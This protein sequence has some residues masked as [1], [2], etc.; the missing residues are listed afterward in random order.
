[1]GLG[2]LSS[3]VG[4]AKIENSLVDLEYPRSYRVPPA[5]AC[6]QSQA[7]CLGG[8]NVLLADPSCGPCGNVTHAWG[9]DALSAD[10]ATE[11]ADATMFSKFSTFYQLENPETD[12][13]LLDNELIHKMAEL[14]RI[15]KI[16]AVDADGIRD[17]AG[18]EWQ[19]G[20][21]DF[22][23]L[24][25]DLPQKLRSQSELRIAIWMLVA[26]RQQTKVL[27][28]WHQKQ[29]DEM[30]VWLEGYIKEKV[31]TGGLSTRATSYPAKASANLERQQVAKMLGVPSLIDEQPGYRG[32]TSAACTHLLYC[33]GLTPT[34]QSVR[35]A[36]KEDGRNDPSWH[37]LFNGFSNKFG[38]DSDIVFDNKQS[39]KRISAAD[40]LRLEGVYILQLQLVPNKV[41]HPEASLEYH[42]LAFDGDRKVLF[43]DQVVHGNGVQ[44]IS[45]DELLHGVEQHTQMRKNKQDVN[46]A[47]RGKFKA[48]LN[49]ADWYDFKFTKIVKFK[50]TVTV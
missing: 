7:A 8:G 26:V 19:R 21:Y 32:C 35:D 31:R 28:G 14:S 42:M 16:R 39:K 36:L 27:Y 20:Q 41:N 5:D 13:A 22:H 3:H 17:L 25:F 23:G 2:L 30:I 34:P 9:G 18:R 44:S 49:P 48:L 47:C 37:D 1:M 33:L 45:Q 46:R 40:V 50:K 38:L 4:S 12:V 11:N 24:E 10:A 6:G 15:L 29:I 43:D